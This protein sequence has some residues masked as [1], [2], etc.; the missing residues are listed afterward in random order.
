MR[1][2]AHRD[3][4]QQRGQRQPK[5]YFNCERLKHKRIVPFCK[6][7]L[8]GY[9]AVRILRAAGFEKVAYLEGGVLGWPY[10]LERDPVKPTMTNNSLSA[11]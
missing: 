7:S 6:I 8:R 2:I 10:E 4:K 11:I 3:K 1:T 5:L 9:E